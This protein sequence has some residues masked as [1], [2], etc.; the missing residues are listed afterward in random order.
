[1][2]AT[3]PHPAV[4]WLLVAVIAA[5]PVVLVLAF[6]GINAENDAERIFDAESVGRAYDAAHRFDSATNVV[7]LLAVAAIIGVAMW[8]RANQV[9]V[10][11]VPLA[12]GALGVLFV[13]GGY[14]AGWLWSL[15]LAIAAVMTL[16]LIGRVVRA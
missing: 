1:M 5:F 12:L 7:T 4:R 3:P 15:V 16:R 14:A 2:T 11:K 10:P 13:R 8:V 9:A 6:A